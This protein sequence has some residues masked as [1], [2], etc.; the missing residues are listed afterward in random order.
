[1]EN[2]G[3]V[4]KIMAEALDEN[5]KGVII[6]DVKIDYSHVKELAAHVIEEEHS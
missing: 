5:A 3:D 6:V 4:K 2:E 1:M